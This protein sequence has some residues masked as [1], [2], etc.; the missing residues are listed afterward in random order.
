MKATTQSNRPTMK[1][2]TSASFGSQLSYDV[3]AVSLSEVIS[4]MT[5]ALDLTEGAF[6]GHALR[7][8][9]LAMRLGSALGISKDQLNSL[10]YA[11]LLKDI[12]CS[13]NASRMTELVN[14]DDRAAKKA[15]KKTS[16]KRR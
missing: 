12:G 3:G 8:C 2:E 6:P 7:S 11:T 1:P 16:A 14:G 5:F 4:A 10:Y 13:T 9:L 15:A